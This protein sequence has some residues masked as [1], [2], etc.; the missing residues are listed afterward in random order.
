[1]LISSERI[2]S[3]LQKGQHFRTLADCAAVRSEQWGRL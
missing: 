1:M 2:M 3:L